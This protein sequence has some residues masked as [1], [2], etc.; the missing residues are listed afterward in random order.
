MICRILYNSRTIVWFIVS[1]NFDKIE[2]CT[3]L[4]REVSVWNCREK[5][6]L[7]CSSKM[8]VIIVFDWEVRDFRRIEF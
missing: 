2:N 5:L 3:K 6:V 7:W 8:K 1:E 4:S